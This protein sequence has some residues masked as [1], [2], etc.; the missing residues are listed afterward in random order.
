MIAKRLKKIIFILTWRGE[1]RSELQNIIWTSVCRALE[2]IKTVG[3]N[4]NNSTNVA[5]IINF[6]NP[7]VITED[8]KTFEMLFDTKSSVSIDWGEDSSVTNAVKMGVDPF[9][10]KYLVSN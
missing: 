2:K 10:V 3:T 9:K 7:L 8:V 6:N 5:Y 4:R 1:S